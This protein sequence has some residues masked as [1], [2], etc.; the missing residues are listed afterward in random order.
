[1]GGRGGEQKAQEEEKWILEL[2]RPQLN[3]TRCALCSAV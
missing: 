2:Y 1:M 3:L